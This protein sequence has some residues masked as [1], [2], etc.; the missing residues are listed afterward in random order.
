MLDPSD[1]FLY[2]LC[3]P[4]AL[5]GETE[6]N[7]PHCQALLTVRVND[8]CGEGSYQCCKCRGDFTVDWGGG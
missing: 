7:C 3:F 5:T 6:I 2:E 8:P 4:G 1:P